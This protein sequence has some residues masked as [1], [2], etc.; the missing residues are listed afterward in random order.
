MTFT[1]IHIR[2]GDYPP[3]LKEISNPPMEIH[4]RGGL[5]DASLP[6]VAVVGTRKA[7]RDGRELA[8]QTAGELARAG[9]VIVSGLAMG[10][11]T[12]AHRGAL[13]EEGITVAV[14]GNGIDTIYPA[15]NQKLAEHIIAGGGA[16]V[17][18]Y[19]P[20]E[21]S[22]KGN[23]IERNRIIS[24][25]CLGVVVIEAPE[26]SGAI[27]TARFAGEQGR[28]VF[29]FPGG[30]RNKR[31]AGSHELIRDGATLATSTKEILEDIGIESSTTARA[32]RKKLKPDEYAV[33]SIIKEAGRP[34]TVDRIIELTTLE[35]HIVSRIIT[36]LTIEGIIK[37]GEV[38]YELSNS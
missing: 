5:P 15:Q 22:F 17:S 35:P 9:V 7:T 38:G 24:G 6:M 14:L 21:P 20:G 25:L 29:V 4:V 11:D 1:S 2:D 3:F 13:D 32:S 33:V 34:L 12:A 36:S 8:R 19:G 30:A 28:G 18:E 10:I 37:E 16:I 31:Y 23:F 26:R 27:T